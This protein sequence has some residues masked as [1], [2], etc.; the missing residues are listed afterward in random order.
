MLMIN[1]ITGMMIGHWKCDQL[2]YDDDD[3]DYD[4]DDVYDYDYDYD[5]ANDDVQN[6]DRHDDWALKIWSTLLWWR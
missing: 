6:N 1:T 4:Y 2:Y 5:F 3:D